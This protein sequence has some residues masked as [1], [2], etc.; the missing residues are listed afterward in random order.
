M[1]TATNS[2]PTPAEDV[3]ALLPCPF[4][5]QP[6]EL[7]YEDGENPDERFMHAECTAG[8]CIAQR[9][10]VIPAHRALA[11]AIWNERR[12]AGL[13]N[14][15]LSAVEIVPREVMRRIVAE[16]EAAAKHDWRCTDHA[17]AEFFGERLNAIN[18]ALA[19][20]GGEV[21]K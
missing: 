15:D 3:P 20:L 8:D 6:A 9:L 13:T 5:G 14:P 17:T 4:C 1:S 18:A 7:L 11:A 21:G 2:K 19:A 16:L 12:F 10:G